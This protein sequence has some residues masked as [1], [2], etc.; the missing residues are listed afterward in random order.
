MILAVIPA[1][2]GSK[3]VKDKN[4]RPLGGR[5]LMAWS[6]KAALACKKIDKV[7]VSTDSD[8]YA[9]L[10]KFYGAEIINRPAELAQDDTPMIKVLQHTL[11]ANS[12]DLIVLLDPTS[13]FRLVQDIDACLEKIKEPETDSVVTV[14]ESE[15]NPYFIMGTIGSKDY[16]QY[17]LIKQEQPVTRRQEAPQ[18]YQLNAGVYAIKKE[19]IATGKIFTPKTK[20][21]V[22][23]PERSVHIDTEMDFKFA[24]FLLKEK[25][26]KVDF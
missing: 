16:W 2:S 24:E 5:P 17:P 10:A 19:I 25:Y 20:T 7:V 22:M 15:H 3:S 18:V 11:K 9:Q 6:I 21:V 23:P 8:K 12:A 26:V 1:R 14:T 13:P 4:I